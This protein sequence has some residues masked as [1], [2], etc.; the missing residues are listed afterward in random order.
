[1]IKRGKK[2]H[3]NIGKEEDDDFKDEDFDMPT[4][5]SPPKGPVID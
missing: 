5:K 1:L 3:T 2:L 4:P